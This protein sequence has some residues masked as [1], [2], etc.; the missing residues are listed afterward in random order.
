MTR[1]VLFRVLAELGVPADAS[2]PVPMAALEAKAD[3]DPRDMSLRDAVIAA[4]GFLTAEQ[5]LGPVVAGVLR[6]RLVRWDAWSTTWIGS[7]ALSGGRTQV[8]VLRPWATRDPMLR[9]ILAR[10][11]RSLQGLVEG[12]RL[13]ADGAAIVAPLPG[14]EAQPVPHGGHVGADALVALVVRSIGHLL[15]WEQAGLGL[16]QLEAAEL[17]DAGDRLVAITLTPQPPSDAATVLRLIAG[18]VRAWWSEATEHPLA[19]L[20]SGFDEL[21]PRTIA[22]AADT[23]RAALASVLADTRHDILRR[24]RLLRQRDERTRLALAIH[25]LSAAIAPPRGRA[26]VGVGL[27][28]RT[29]V[30]QNY[31]RVVLWGPVGERPDVIWSEQE[32]I[33]PQLARRLLRVRGSAPVSERLN[34]EVEG[35]PAYVDRIARWAAGQLELRTLRMLLQLP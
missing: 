12:V 9:R 20:L 28:G 29:L 3:A 31:D 30:V 34:R 5:G 6:E 25:R 8:R 33:D 15:R 18:H 16:D 13:D 4:H 11:A 10:D 35:N 1:S 21:P 32:G 2:G 23:C 14:P 17:C 27:D 7:H 26:A 24:D 22:E 19:D